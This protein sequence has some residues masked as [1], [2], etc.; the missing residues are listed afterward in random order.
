MFSTLTPY[1]HHH[2]QILIFTAEIDPHFDNKSMI[3]RK[4]P[5]RYISAGII[6]AVAISRYGIPV[7]STMMNAAEAMIG[8]SKPPLVDAATSMPPASDTVTFVRNTPL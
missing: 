7:T 4:T 3:K 2:K 6:A 8:G 5:V 1:N